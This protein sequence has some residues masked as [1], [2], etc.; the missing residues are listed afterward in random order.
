MVKFVASASSLPSFSASQLRLTKPSPAAPSTSGPRF[1]RGK[2][3]GRKR[4]GKAD[5]GGGDKGEEEK[6]QADGEETKADGGALDGAGSG[7]RDDWRLEELRVKRTFVG[8]LDGDGGGN[9][10]ASAGGVYVLLYSRDAT[11]YPLTVHPVDFVTMR[12]VAQYAVLSLEE[13]EQRMKVRTKRFEKLINAVPTLAKLEGERH[14]D[15]RREQRQAEVGAGGEGGEGEAGG[16]GAGGGDDGQGVQIKRKQVVGVFHGN[17]E[18][19]DD[20]ALLDSRLADSTASRAGKRSGSGD[21]AGAGDDDEDDD[22]DPFSFPTSSSSSAGRRGARPG[23]KDR[24][25]AIDFRAEFDDDDETHEEPSV[26][27]DADV[28]EEEA[29]N[30]DEPTIESEEE[31]DN[32]AGKKRTEELLKK[33]EEEEK[34]R[35]EGMDKGRK[36]GGKGTKGR[37][38]AEDDSDEDDEDDSDDSG[39]GLSSDDD[40]DE[41]DGDDLSDDVDDD[42]DMED[43][44]RKV[45]DKGDGNRVN[46]TITQT[47]TAQPS[48]LPLPASIASSSAT[49]ASASA[50]SS[51]PSARVSAAERDRKRSRGPESDGAT[52]SGKGEGALVGDA[53]SATTSDSSAAPPKRPRTIAPS[54]AAAPSASAPSAGLPSTSTS[55]V[56]PLTDA[57]VLAEFAITPRLTVTELTKRL[58]KSMAPHPIDKAAFIDILKRCCEL[59]PNTKTLSVK[60]HNTS[61][62]NATPTPAAAGGA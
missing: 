32:E 31:E 60:P 35:R 27:A 49:F 54:S 30:V 55:A 40:A 22:D 37:G 39:D 23:R 34:E 7:S 28:E 16:G 3:K 4:T 47:P 15:Q 53:Q 59:D 29:E 58:T 21:L 52:V 2:G 51:A 8:H 5:G 25:A 24:E 26:L 18:G 14:Q 45:Q 6:S 9:S 56:P 50:L 62:T 12:E 43:G 20:V 1:E 41:D 46:L 61:N 13:A 42:V 17:V 57:V 11:R 33:A 19:E 10:G 36:K 48:P 38:Q 44:E